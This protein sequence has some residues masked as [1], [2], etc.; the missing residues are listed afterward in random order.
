MKSKLN[1]LIKVSLNRKIKSKW[2]VLANVLI[3]V[4]L[5]GLTNIDN[6][7]NFFGGDFEE[8]Q[9]I[10]V[11]DDTSNF[12]II[13][14]NL[15]ETQS[16]L[17]YESKYEIINYEQSVEK[18]KELIETGEVDVIMQIETS[19]DDVF[20]VNLISDDYI[21]TITSQIFSIALTNAR[22]QIVLL[23]SDISQEQLDYIYASVT[24]T[25]EYLDETK[26]QEAANNEMIGSVAIQLIVIP[27]FMLTLFLVQMIGAEV[28]DEKTTRGMEIIISNVSP[29]T[30]FFAKVVAAN[31]F[32]FIQGFLLLIYGFIG[33]FIRFFIANNELS[34]GVS[35]YIAG[36]LNPE[37]MDKIFLAIPFT[38]VIMVV[39][40][41]AY[42]LLAG[43]L[44]SMTTN[45]EDFQQLQTPIILV[46]LL[47]Y[48]LAL[49]ANLFEGALFIKIFSFVP[50][51]S[52]ILT[53]CL[54]MLGQVSVFEFIISI[55]LVIIT[56]YYLIKYGLR[57]YKVGI[58]NY[59]SK[60]LWKKMFKALKNKE[61]S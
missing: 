41:I 61:N 16:V 15:Y 44:A 14:E 51:V 18:A 60:D 9:V 19:I 36:Q 13:F 35:D 54:F 30:H 1:Y 45:T 53:P 33:L 34:V 29:K 2:F 43:I 4:V 10:Y 22:T 27:F 48:Y 37:L 25:N 40:L 11:I 49:F 23:D 17:G 7:I 32:V 24:I 20:V 31:L 42:S 58:L 28:N 50:F 52:A 46:S 21:D 26:T 56:N 47:G 55:V 8:K 38:L 39:T 57:I 59:S 3:A 12:D 6:V 5:I